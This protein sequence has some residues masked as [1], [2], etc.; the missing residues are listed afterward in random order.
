MTPVATIAAMKHLLMWKVIF[1]ICHLT[2][3]A[4]VQLADS[5][6]VCAFPYSVRSAG[7]QLVRLVA[8]AEMMKCILILVTSPLT[9]DVAWRLLKQ[10]IVAAYHCTCSSVLRVSPVCS[11]PRLQSEQH[12]L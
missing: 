1:S 2:V 11:L 3:W 12:M 7:M 10:A 4:Y 9:R 6:E 8:I 5:T